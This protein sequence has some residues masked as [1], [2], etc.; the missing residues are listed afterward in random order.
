[1]FAGF[2]D[3]HR[4]LNLSVT[5]S[6]YSYWTVARY[7]FSLEYRFEAKFK[8][9]LHPPTSPIL[10]GSVQERYFSTDIM[11]GSPYQVWSTLRPKVASNNIGDVSI[12][13]YHAG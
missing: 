5:Y 3:I 4:D 7:T 11:E 2:L 9:F 6:D 8:T 10:D 1:M 12:F 13:N